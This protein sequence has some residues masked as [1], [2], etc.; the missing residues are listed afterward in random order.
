[1]LNSGINT[2]LYTIFRAMKES[3]LK[4]IIAL[5]TIA[6]VAL[7][8]VQLYWITES[9]ELEE[10]RFKSN[11]NETLFRVSEKLEKEETANVIIKRFSDVDGITEEIC[12]TILPNGKALFFVSELNDSLI[13]TESFI[14]PGRPVKPKTPQKSTKFRESKRRLFSE[15]KI[16]FTE[17][18]RSSHNTDSLLSIEAINDSF[19]IQRREFVDEIVEEIFTSNISIPIDERINPEFLNSFIKE[20][21]L[22]VG[23][24]LNYQFAV[25]DYDLDSLVIIS[26]SSFFRELSDTPY[27]AALFS[28]EIFNRSSY[29]LLHFPEEGYYFI[30]SIQSLLFVSIGLLLFIVGI[31]IIQQKHSLSKKKVTEIKN[32]LI[33]NITHEFKTLSLQFL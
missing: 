21:L 26:D 20:E 11:I 32:D 16:H 17:L 1:M 9:V 5:M 14:P 6:V 24:D 7:I 13:D 12:D 27:R 22:T 33:N 31:F 15:N 18:V 30:Q 25:Q 23:I 4:I 28:N 29:L 8:T 3:K 19:I 2:L 10:E